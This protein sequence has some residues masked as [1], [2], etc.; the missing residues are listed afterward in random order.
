MLIR[1][2]SVKQF[3]PAVLSS[4]LQCRVYVVKKVDTVSSLQP[5][6]KHRHEQ[7]LTLECLWEREEMLEEPSGVIP[8]ST[9]EGPPDKVTLC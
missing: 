9:Q 7:V 2:A 3:G 4:G 1:Q 5:A 8:T 6:G